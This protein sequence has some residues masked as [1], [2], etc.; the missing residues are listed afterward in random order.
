MG[1]QVCTLLGPAQKA[2]TQDQR[3]PRNEANWNQIQTR[4]P[5]TPLLTSV[6]Y[7]SSVICDLGWIEHGPFLSPYW[8]SVPPGHTCYPCSGNT[9]RLAGSPLAISPD[10]C[11]LSWFLHLL[12]QWSSSILKV[13]DSPTESMEAL[14]RGGCGQSGKCQ[15]PKI[16]RAWAVTLPLCA[17]KLI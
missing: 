2:K 1:L 6:A 17:I 3:S 13:P 8:P 15:M 10:R 4:L 16:T 14:W 9:H 7:Q 11:F 12:T 5:P